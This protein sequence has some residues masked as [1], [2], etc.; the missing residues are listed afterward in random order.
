MGLGLGIRVWRF[1]IEGL[2]CRVLSCALALGTVYGYHSSI[3]GIGILILSPK[4]GDLPETPKV[5]KIVAPNS[6]TS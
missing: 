1:S 6:E 5:G 2:A 4:P 3:R